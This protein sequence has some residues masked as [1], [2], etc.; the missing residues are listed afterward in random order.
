M[1]TL[2]QPFTR[3]FVW[4]TAKLRRVLAAYLLTR[5]V[6]VLTFGTIEDWSFFDAYWWGEVASLTIGYGDLAPQTDLGR[7][8]AGPFHF[9]WVYYCGLAIAG[10]IVLAVFKNRNEMTHEEQEWLFHVVTVVYG[11]VRWL[12]QARLDDDPTLAQ[13]VPVPVRDEA[14]ELEECP[15]QPHDTEEGDLEPVPLG[16]AGTP[17]ARTPKQQDA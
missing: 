13:R 9:F 17:A 2:L 5:L 3:L 8:L 14:G 10:H 1:R 7:L 11:W 6:A 16:R 4:T 15:E 12:V